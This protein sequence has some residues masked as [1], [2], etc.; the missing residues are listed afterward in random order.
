M[1]TRLINPYPFIGEKHTEALDFIIANLP[2]NPEFDQ[3]NDAVVAAVS[4]ANSEVPLVN[5]LIQVSLSTVLPNV[6]NGYLNTGTKSNAVYTEKQQVII[7]DLFNGVKRVPVESIA[8]FLESVAENIVSSGLTFQE[9]LPLF[10]AADVGISDHTYWMAQI[11]APGTWAAYL[12][13]DA[14]RNYLQ[15]PN[16]VTAA[17]QGALLGYGFVKHPQFQPADILCMM[18]GSTGLVAGKVVF[19]WVPF[20]EGC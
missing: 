14:I 12:N 3:L 2:A 11:A 17:M 8:L 1:Q 15:V 4:P 5:E 13:P 7:N 6:V 20:Q 18:T 19:S 9:Q 16:W 10:A